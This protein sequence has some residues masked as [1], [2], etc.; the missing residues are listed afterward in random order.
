MNAH[1]PVPDPSRDADELAFLAAYDASEFPHPSVAVDVALV[2]VAG[3]VLHALLVRREEH[4][5]KGRWALPGGFVGMTESLED[6]ASRVLRDKVGLDDVFVEQLYTFGAVDRDPRT[7][8]ISVTYFALVDH[9]RLRSARPENGAVR[10]ATLD[11]PWEGLAG[12]EV[13]ASDA[14]GVV[15]P[16]AF[17]HAAILGVAV[18]RLRGKL[19]YT[20][21]GFELLPPRFT[22]RQLQTV[23]ETVLGHT[24][25]KDSFRR[26]M[27]ASG[28]LAAT[29]ERERDV[30][31]RPAEL[32]EIEKE[33]GESPRGD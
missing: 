32:Y 11:V 27:L 4:P 23:H 1:D 16:L 5:A 20:P 21:V 8:V 2:T 33:M 6:A 17:D 19:D 26:R 14:E 3:G 24:V 31:H 30:L 22:L 15:L 12:G 28:R 18:Q 29:G 25:N 10:L 9:D 13:R 7:R